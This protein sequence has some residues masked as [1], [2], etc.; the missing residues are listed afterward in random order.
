[1]GRA[2]ALAHRNKLI[3]TRYLYPQN[4]CENLSLPLAG[5]QQ[6]HQTDCILYPAQYLY[7]PGVLP[8]SDYQCILGN[9][10]LRF[11]LSK[12]SGV[13][14]P[15]GRGY[16]MLDSIVSLGRTAAK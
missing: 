5:F 1:M 8:G 14:L 15:V 2:D 7:D 9:V 12:E 4:P 16:F 3:H 10:Y 6:R 11:D 13:L